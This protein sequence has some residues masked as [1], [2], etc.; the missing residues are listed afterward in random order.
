MLVEWCFTKQPRHF[1]KNPLF[2]GKHSDQNYRTA[3]T[4]AQRKIKSKIF[5]GYSNQKLVGSVEAL[6]L[7]D[8]STYTATALPS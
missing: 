3:M 7:N 5:E 6:A 1:S 2:C 4:V 8:F